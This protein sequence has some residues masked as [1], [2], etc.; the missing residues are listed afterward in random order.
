MTNFTVYTPENAPEKSRPILKDLQ[1]KLGFVPNVLGAMAESP[2]T[3]K[4]WVDIK[5]SLESGLLSLTERKIVHMTASFLNNSGYC[6]A[7]GT[8]LSEKEGVPREILEALRED[9]PLK[10]AKL[11]ALRIFTKS[12]LK[13]MGRPDDADIAAVRKAGYTN[14]QILEVILGISHGI[15]GNYVNHLVRVSLDKQFEGNRFEERKVNARM[16]DAA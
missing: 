5:T 2:A 1:G 12:V 16:S 9:R 11:E 10:D 14:A 13:R 15:L 7:A 3:L 4:S 6:M 8:T